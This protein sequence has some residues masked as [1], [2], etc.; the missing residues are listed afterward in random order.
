MVATSW[1]PSQWPPGGDLDIL[2]LRAS[3]AH[4]G[5]LCIPLIGCKHWHYIDQP[6]S[7]KECW[8][9]SGKSTFTDTTR[10]ARGIASGSASKGFGH[11]VKQGLW[12]CLAQGQDRQCQSSSSRKTFLTWGGDLGNLFKFTHQLTSLCE[13]NSTCRNCRVS[14]IRCAHT[15]AGV[16]PQVTQVKAYPC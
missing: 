10:P 5:R 2:K 14:A 8:T 9:T 1:T 13:A 16:Y 4:S 15:P 6:T 3:S 11:Q 12:P 7:P